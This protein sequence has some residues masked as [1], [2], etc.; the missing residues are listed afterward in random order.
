MES[1][2]DKLK[3]FENSYSFN[4]QIIKILIKLIS[5]IDVSKID[6]N[7][8]RIFIDKDELNINLYSITNVC[9]PV[10]I[11]L[12]KNVINIYIG[13]ELL[14]PLDDVFIKNEIVLKKTIE[15]LE[16]VFSKNIKEELFYNDKRI[17]SY[18]YS[19][20]NSSK[21]ALFYSNKHIS[22]NKTVINTYQSWI[23]N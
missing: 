3:K 9:L 10:N 18:N 16:I 19:Y 12:W 1:I 22:N 14:H 15:I 7:K 11:L 20:I 4:N 21:D 8:S 2:I 17:V 6:F 13:I 23:N 5:K